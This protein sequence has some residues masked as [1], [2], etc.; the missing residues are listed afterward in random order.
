M[1]LWHISA[2]TLPGTNPSELAESPNEAVGT[3]RADSVRHAELGAATTLPLDRPNAR[4]VPL[5][6]LPPVVP[7]GEAAECWSCNNCG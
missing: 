5:R 2:N 3:S 1:R 4:S 6:Q 7:Q